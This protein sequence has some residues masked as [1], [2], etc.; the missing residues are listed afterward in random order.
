MSEEGYRKMK[1][2][3]GEYVLT[4]ENSHLNSQDGINI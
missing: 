3:L 4:L 1:K 2:V